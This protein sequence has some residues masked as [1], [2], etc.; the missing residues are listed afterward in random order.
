VRLRY[1]F[2]GWRDGLV[3]KS[4]ACSCKELGFGS[5]KPHGGSQ[6]PLTPDP[7]SLMPSSGLC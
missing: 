3:V 5:Q 6:L 1:I 7:G 4:T 2:R